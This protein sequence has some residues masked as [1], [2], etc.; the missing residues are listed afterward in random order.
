MAVPPFSC[1]ALPHT[2]TQSRTLAATQL[3]ESDTKFGMTPIALQNTPH[4]SDL[5]SQF[6]HVLQK[7][8]QNTSDTITSKLTR[9]ICEVGHCTSV[10][11]ERV[12]KL[13][14]ISTNHEEE[15]DPWGRKLFPPSPPGGHFRK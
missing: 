14:V 2:L 3:G 6:E 1:S 13:Q 8:L 5:L 15:M 10:F 11:E 4:S 7:A 9:E 12:D